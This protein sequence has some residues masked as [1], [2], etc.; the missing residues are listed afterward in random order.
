MAYWIASRST[1]YLQQISENET[2]HPKSED[3]LQGSLIF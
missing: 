2:D 3:Y 1:D